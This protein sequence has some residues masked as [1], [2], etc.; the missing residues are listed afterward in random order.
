MTSEV[1]AR[2]AIH[3]PIGDVLTATASAV[4]VLFVFATLVFLAIRLLPGDPTVMI[5]GDESTAAE[6]SRLA[7]ALGFNQPL[8]VQ[9]G[10]YV[11]GLCRLDL[12]ASLSHPDRSAFGCVLAAFKNTACLALVSVTLG[13]FGGVG[14]ALLSVGPWLGPY[15]RRV[16]GLI[17]LAAALPMLAIAPLAT[18]LLAVKW[19]WI[20]L[21]G[22]PDHASAGLLFAASLLALPLGAQMARIGR[23]SL[24]EQQQALYLNTARAKGASAWR[25]WCVH[26]LPVAAG[27]L[28]VVLAT[29]LGALL[30][31]AVVIERFF[32]RPGLGTLML[33]AYSSRDIPVL[34]ASIVA[35]GILFAIAQSVAA[36]ITTLVDP[37]GQRV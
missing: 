17:I 4:V 14:A 27:P 8:L 1:R 3:G 10:K 25:V 33:D 35:A 12:G 13:A 23:A 6:R 30:G 11:E 22:D 7:S 32:E 16:H 2:G 20:S 26:A 24:L 5:L 36:A 18:W 29:Q 9:Y 31:G 15:A 21:P 37:R 28:F 34:E 19:S